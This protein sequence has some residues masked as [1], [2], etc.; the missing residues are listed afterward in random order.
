MTAQGV[1]LKGPGGE[2][3]PWRRKPSE[4][5]HSASLGSWIVTAAFAHPI[6]SQYA[7]SLI[8]LRPIEGTPDAHVRLAG[9]THELLVSA[10]DPK[11]KMT[12]EMDPEVTLHY[13]IPMN[14]QCQFVAPSDA[15]AAQRLEDVIL[16]VTEGRLSP[17]T[18]FRRHFEQCV[19]RPF[20]GE[21]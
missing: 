6:W 11:H 2:A 13:L 5:A 14:H 10:L 3:W 1:L 8:H 20:A 9:A 7:F 4:A 16:A 19:R 21:G 18:D 15:A 12:P 17:D